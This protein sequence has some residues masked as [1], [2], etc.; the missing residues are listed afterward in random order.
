GG[1]L[2]NPQ[3]MN[4]PE[5]QGGGGDG[6]KLNYALIGSMLGI[7]A[8][9][10]Y[11]TTLLPLRS[12]LF[13]FKFRDTKIEI[14]H[15][16]L[17][18]QSQKPKEKEF[19]KALEMETKQEESASVFLNQVKHRLMERQWDFCSYFVRSP[20]MVA[21]EKELLVFTA[22]ESLLA[23]LKMEDGL[24]DIFKNDRTYANLFNTDERRNGSL[25]WLYLRYWRLQLTLQSHQRAEAA[26][27]GI[28]TKK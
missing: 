23:H 16:A 1:N 20:K 19:Q 12:T 25:M 21:R 5:R 2:N 11:Y 13:Q 22:K 7:A 6:S 28:Q 27:L 24:R 17:D 8:F 9:G 15:H 4:D 3:S 26:I 18:S 14:H 10:M